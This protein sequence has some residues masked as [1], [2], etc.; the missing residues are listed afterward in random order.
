MKLLLAALGLLVLFTSE[1]NAIKIVVPPGQMECVAETV[2]DEHFLVGVHKVFLRCAFPHL[3]LFFPQVA[4]G[5]RID[6]RVLVSGYSQ[7]YVPF[8]AV[9]V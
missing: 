4:G 8:I 1:I 6:G 3:H 9:K 2:E 5:P 7:Y